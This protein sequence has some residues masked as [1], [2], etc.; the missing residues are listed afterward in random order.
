V[1]NQQNIVVF[2]VT[3]REKDVIRIKIRK[4]SDFVLLPNKDDPG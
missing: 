3:H 4:P 2:Y 1:K